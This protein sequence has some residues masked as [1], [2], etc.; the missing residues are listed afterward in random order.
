LSSPWCALQHAKILTQSDISFM[1]RWALH[2]GH[3][4]HK[5]GSQKSILQD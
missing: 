1:E 4:S 5:R 2:E 3:S